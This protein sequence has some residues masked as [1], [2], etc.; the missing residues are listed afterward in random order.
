MKIESGSGRQNE[1]VR[2][3]EAIR[4]LLR[5]YRLESQFDEARLVDSWAAL[6]G[7]P[8]ARRT[9]KVYVK[10]QILFVEME[11]AALKQDMSLH[12]E[13]LMDLIRAQFG[14]TAIREIR[15]L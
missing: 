5:S 6:V 11:S 2:L 10:N 8:V 7:K 4:R 3:A 14:E 9:R 13:K 1:P 12:K 15:I